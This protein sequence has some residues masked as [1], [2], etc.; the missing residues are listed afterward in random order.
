VS[1][2]DLWKLDPAR[3]GSP[4]RGETGDTRPCRSSLSVNAQIPPNGRKLALNGVFD[5]FSGNR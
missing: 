5:P 1:F 4:L 3:A 2:L